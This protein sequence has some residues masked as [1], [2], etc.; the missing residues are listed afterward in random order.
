MSGLPR[1]VSPCPT[2]SREPAVSVLS[3]LIADLESDSPNEI[4][5]LAMSVRES[6]QA[7]WVKMG[8]T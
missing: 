1:I 4:L 8:L 7:N 6:G 3:G 5:V 2:S